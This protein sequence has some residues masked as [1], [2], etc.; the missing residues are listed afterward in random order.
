M[1][2]TL[3]GDSQ[4][5]GTVYWGSGVPSGSKGIETTKG[6][7]P[8]SY[9]FK[10]DTCSYITVP[11][12][13]KML[14]KGCVGQDKEGNYVFCKE[15][16]MLQYFKTNE[17]TVNEIVAKTPKD[18]PIV[19]QLG[20][21]DLSAIKGSKGD[22]KLAEDV[23]KKVDE[24]IKY[25]KEQM[26]KPE[27]KGKKVIFVGVPPRYGV[28]EDQNEKVEKFNTLMKKRLPELG[29]SFVD[30]YAYTM[31]KDLMKN[32]KDSK[33]IHYGPTAKESMYKYMVKEIDKIM[34]KEQRLAMEEN[35]NVKAS[36]LSMNPTSFERGR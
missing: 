18:Q 6:N 15:G 13:G 35:L 3:F 21:N 12:R 5:V 11:Y 34:L 24:Y 31:E 1:G 19:F 22:K 17:K 10:G 30:L 32:Q 9:V 25:F 16:A 36:D 7:I 8:S 28:A 27:W 26:K 4:G 14:K 33:G 29:I 20:G 23:E 2:M